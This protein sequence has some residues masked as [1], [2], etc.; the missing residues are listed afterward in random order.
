MVRLLHLQ[1]FSKSS[2]GKKKLKVKITRRCVIMFY[3]LFATFINGFAGTPVNGVTDFNNLYTCSFVDLTG[4]QSAGATGLS[5]TNV[6]GYDFKI[7]SL[8]NT[9]D[10]GIGIEP[11]TGQTAM[12]YGYTENGIST[13]DSLEITSNGMPYFDLQSVD[14]SMDNSA[15]TSRNVTLTGYHNGS[16]VPG[17]TLTISLGAASSGTLL[18]TFD[19][20]SNTAFIGID[21]FTIVVPGSDVGAIGVDNV[22]AINFRSSILPL[23]LISFS[24]KSN[25]GGIQLNWNTTNEINSSSFA[26]ERSLNGTDFK[27]IGNVRAD[28]SRET[29]LHNYVFQDI[30][31]GLNSAYYYRLK[32]ADYDGNFSYSGIIKV[33][34]SGRQQVYFI[35]PN[36]VTSQL[37]HLRI[38]PETDGEIKVLTISAEGKILGSSRFT[39]TVNSQE[40]YFNVQ[41]SQ[42][43]AGTYHLQ[44][45]ELK[46]GLITT[47]QFVKQ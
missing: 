15:L 19:V 10:C 12:V 40:N 46:T 43:P 2:Q 24:G 34:C 42:L 27:D 17:A 4:I 16:L 1:N 22:N 31:S 39:N 29:S 47:L 32:L 20:S 8:N 35:Y 3:F 13:V 33:N 11:F 36:P 37:L 5:A 6:D 38:P 30:I 9:A 45:N 26:I 18:T 41:V 25:S 21:K 23:T 44:I 28:V 7:F 14:I